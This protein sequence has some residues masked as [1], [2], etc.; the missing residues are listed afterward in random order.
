MHH[1]QN[2]IHL[3]CRNSKDGYIPGQI[4]T[5]TMRMSN[6]YECH[7]HDFFSCYFMIL[8]KCCTPLGHHLHILGGN[9]TAT[10]REG[11]RGEKETQGW[12]DGDH[13]RGTCLTEATYKRDRGEAVEG[14]GE[15][16]V[17]LKPS[18]ALMCLCPAESK[19][20]ENVSA[21]PGGLQKDTCRRK[22]TER[23]ERWRV[24]LK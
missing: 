21:V 4:K 3:R 22:P 24:R 19:E 15:E 17:F 5:Q 6:C 11:E 16:R 2:S 13:S 8:S 7:K 14:A 18:G 1:K 12:E 20:I 10:R 23:T 9:K